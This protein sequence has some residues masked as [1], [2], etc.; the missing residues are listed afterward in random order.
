MQNENKSDEM[1]EIERQD[2]NVK[3]LSDES[4]NKSADEMMRQV[5]RGDE[6]SG[7]ADERDVVG[8]E[9]TINTLQGR[10]RA[11]KDKGSDS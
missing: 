11:K 3:K 5:L 6:S 4:A 8:A 10:E 2:W 9:K 7:D 1:P